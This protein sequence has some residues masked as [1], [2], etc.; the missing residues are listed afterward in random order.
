MQRLIKYING[1]LRIYILLVNTNVTKEDVT[2]IQRDLQIIQVQMKSL[3]NGSEVINNNINNQ[4][5]P[6][7]YV[8]SDLNTNLTRATEDRA[9]SSFGN[10]YK[11]CHGE[12]LI[13]SDCKLLREC[14]FTFISSTY[15][16]IDWLDNIVTT[17]T[18]KK[19]IK[20]IV[21][22][23]DFVYSDNLSICIELNIENVWVCNYHKTIIVT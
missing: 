7:V 16:S 2:E 6:C 4:R 3:Q 10:L 17:S 8:M 12:R 20:Y 18:G 22:H 23:N 9:S 19:R 13:I 21:I 11:F 14:I 1:C 15:Y 5:F